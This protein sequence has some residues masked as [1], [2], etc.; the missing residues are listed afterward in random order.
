MI[1]EVTATSSKIHFGATGVEEVLQNVL[2]II[3][4][5]IFS[6]PLDRTFGID[7]SLLDTPIPV[8]M[9]RIQAE[10]YAKI[11]KYEPRAVLKEVSFVQSTE[12]ALDGRLI[13]KVKVEVVL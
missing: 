12:Q 1:Y 10:I 8:A 3:T 5:P 4:T 2:M 9:A 11:R 13:P 6:V 7:F